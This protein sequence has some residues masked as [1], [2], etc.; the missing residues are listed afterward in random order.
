[1]DKFSALAHPPRRRIVEI[2]SAHSQLPS[3]VLADS[4]GVTPKY[5]SQQLIPLRDAGLVTVTVRGNHR[6]YSLELGGFLEVKEWFG[7]VQS[8]WLDPDAGPHPPGREN[9][10]D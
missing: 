5:V 3:G 2:L 9:G 7:K 6:L 8:L 10:G 1:M 4:L